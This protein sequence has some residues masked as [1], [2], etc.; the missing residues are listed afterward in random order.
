MKLYRP[1]FIM[2]FGRI[3]E[4]ADTVLRFALSDYQMIC[5]KWATKG[6]WIGGNGWKADASCFVIPAKAGIHLL[7]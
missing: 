4:W 1:K 2:F 7:T 5:A 3:E 6:V